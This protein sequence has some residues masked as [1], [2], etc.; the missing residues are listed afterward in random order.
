MNKRSLIKISLE[1]MNQ[2]WN[3]SNHNTNC[4]S[5]IKELTS[6]HQTDVT[7]Q[8]QSK[9]SNMQ[10]QPNQIIFVEGDNDYVITI[11]DFFRL[12]Y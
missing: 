5:H 2:L 1:K 6:M 7:I 3:N 9:Q 8:R 10:Q 11:R 4:N 12:N